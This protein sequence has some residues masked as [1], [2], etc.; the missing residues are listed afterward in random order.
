MTIVAFNVLTINEDCSTLSIFFCNTVFSLRRYSGNLVS[1]NRFFFYIQHS[2]RLSVTRKPTCTG[3]T[4]V[5][6]F[7][8]ILVRRFTFWGM[9]IYFWHQC[10]HRPTLDGTSVHRLQSF[11]FLDFPPVHYRHDWAFTVVFF[12]LPRQ[13]VSVLLEA[14]A[15]SREVRVDREWRPEPGQ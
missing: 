7:A 3:H 8:L 5:G 6:H 14:K 9:N 1:R 13:H 10:I 15:F 2:L 4:F 11:F 12:P